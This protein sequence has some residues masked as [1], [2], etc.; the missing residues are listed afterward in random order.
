ME[1]LENEKQGF[2][3]LEFFQSFNLIRKLFEKWLE[4]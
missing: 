3:C 2:D 4:Q 1:A